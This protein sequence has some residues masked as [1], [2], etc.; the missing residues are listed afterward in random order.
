MMEWNMC[1][2]YRIAIAM[3]TDLLVAGLDMSHRSE[4]TKAVT[5]NFITSKDFNTGREM[6]RSHRNERTKAVAVP[7]LLPEK[8]SHRI[9]A[10]SSIAGS[11]RTKAAAAAAQDKTGLLK[12]LICPRRQERGVNSW[13]RLEA[14]ADGLS[15]ALI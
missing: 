10:G 13:P 15:R 11:E 14:G 9:R 8:E 3:M 2:T 4:R 1:P 6:T 12:Y 7:V 5:V